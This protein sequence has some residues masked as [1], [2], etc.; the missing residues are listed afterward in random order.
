MAAVDL[1]TQG[2]Q[3][4]KGHDSIGIFPLELPVAPI[5]NMGE[6]WFQYK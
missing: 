3:R 1:E 6:I 4:I 2:G 5:V